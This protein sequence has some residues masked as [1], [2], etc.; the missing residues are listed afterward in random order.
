MFTP[1]TNEKYIET[2]RIKL[3]DEELKTIMTALKDVGK[4]IKAHPE[5]NVF[6]SYMF[7]G[8]GIVYNGMA[9]SISSCMRIQSPP[10]APTEYYEPLEDNVQGTLE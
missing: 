9:L 6:V 3:V 1:F 2:I 10:F 5:E 7:S 4:Y 8:H